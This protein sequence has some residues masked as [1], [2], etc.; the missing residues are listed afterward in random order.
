MTVTLS[1]RAESALSD[2][3]EAESKR[4]GST[5]SELLVIAVKELL[6]RLACERDADAY[7]RLTV[8]ETEIVNQ[9]SGTWL[10][11]APGTN[12]DEMFRP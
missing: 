3:L 2:A 10:E 1:F 4:S 6:Y 5:K 11:D 7:D 8:T 9:P 12:W